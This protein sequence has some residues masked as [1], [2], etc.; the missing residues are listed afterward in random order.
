MTA[1]VS[2][3]RAV[4]AGLGV[5]VGLAVLGVPWGM[6]LSVTIFFWRLSGWLKEPATALA[7]RLSAG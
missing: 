1:R 2:L 3:E 6:T 5:A 7:D 4:N